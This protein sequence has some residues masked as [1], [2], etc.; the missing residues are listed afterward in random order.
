MTNCD[1][2]CGSCDKTC[3]SRDLHYH[4]N[5]ASSIKKRYAIVSGK[6]GVGKSSI[7]AM[8]AS[9]N[10]RLNRRTAVLDADITGPSMARMFNANEKLYSNGQFI[11][12]ITTKTGIKVVSSNM[13]LD[14]D[15]TPVVWR[16]PIITG[17]IKQ[18]YQDVLWEDIDTMFI[19]LPPGTGDIPLTVMQSIPLDGIIIVTTPQSLTSMIVSKA[20]NMAKMMNIPIVGI[21]ENMSYIKCLKC[22]EIIYPFNEGKVEELAESF[23]LKVLGKLEIRSEIANK[24]DNGLIEDVVDETIDEIVKSL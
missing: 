12:P 23:S 11:L 9:A 3:D 10:A 7:T 15:T 5:E 6:G 20:I 21:I 1:S 18:F 17:L 14:E 13:L 22:D 16:S 24:A 19:D 2:N 4:L 8:L